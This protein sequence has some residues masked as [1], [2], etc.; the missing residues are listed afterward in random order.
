MRKAVVFL[1]TGLQLFHTLGSVHT[2]AL[3]SKKA[4]NFAAVPHAPQRA[5]KSSSNASSCSPLLCLA[6]PG[7]VPYLLEQPTGL[8]H[9]HCRHIHCH[10]A[11]NPH[12]R[13]SVAI[14]DDGTDGTQH[15]LVDSAVVAVAQLLAGTAAV[16]LPL[17]RLPVG[18]SPLTVT[19][20]LAEGGS[21]L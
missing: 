9:I 4:D 8:L 3:A 15:T 11:A 18:P 12:A 2:V 1:A 17:A 14:A 20:Q 6:H 7:V 16:P 5:A 21:E 13:V 19:V 10:A